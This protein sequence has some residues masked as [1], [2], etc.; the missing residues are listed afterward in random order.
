MKKIVAF[1][2]MICCVL[3]L[4]ACDDPS[5]DNNDKVDYSQAISDMQTVIDA[6]APAVA[7]ITV[8]LKSSLGDLNGSYNVVYNEDGTATVTYSYEK[9]NSFED[10]SGELKS[11]YTGTTTVAADGTVTDS[12]GG[13]ASVEAITFDVQLDESKLG[14]VT[15]GAGSVTAKVKAAD[16]K[17]IL[18]VEIG[19]D[20]DLVI[21]SGKL[22][23]TSVAISYDSASGPVEIVAVYTYVAE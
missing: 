22:G 3:A 6:S 4:A 14:S 5:D 7:D 1:L 15:A 11:T 19:Y 10:I 20:V 13:T 2:L 17:A 23:V 12:L 16:T 8:V 18:G 9:F 21:S